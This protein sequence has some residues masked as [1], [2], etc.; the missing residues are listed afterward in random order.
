ML[1]FFFVIHLTSMIWRS[2]A[3]DKFPIRSVLFVEEGRFVINTIL[4][5]NMVCAVVIIVIFHQIRV[6]ITTTTS[7]S[8]FVL[9]QD[10]LGIKEGRI[11]TFWN[12]K[13]LLFWDLHIIVH[14]KIL[15]KHRRHPPLIWNIL[16]LD[17]IFVPDPREFIH[18][19]R[20]EPI[21]FSQRKSRFGN[22]LEQVRTR[23][24]DPKNLLV[25]VQSRN[26]IFR[27]RLIASADCVGEGG[28]VSLAVAF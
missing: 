14:Q 22:T 25:W 7:H 2:I 15:D 21:G 18:G 5:S 17:P 4:M 16:V 8:D 20:N 27:V 9:L 3:L 28:G 10:R 12:H 26:E 11:N 1:I 19:P 24:L 13:N 6:N 23:V